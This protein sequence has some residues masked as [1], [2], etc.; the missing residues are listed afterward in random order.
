MLGPAEFVDR[1]LHGRAGQRVSASADQVAAGVDGSTL[2]PD[3]RYLAAP[4][5]SRGGFA[6]PRAMPAPAHIVASLKAAGLAPLFGDG[7]EQPTYPNGRDAGSLR[8]QRRRDLS[9]ERPAGAAGSSSSRTTI[10]AAWSA[11]RSRRAPTTTRA[12]WRCFWPS[13]TRWAARGPTL[14]RHVVLLFPDAEE[15]PDVRTERMGSSWFWRNSAAADRTARP[16]AGVRSGWAAARR[17]RFEP[18]ARGCAVR[19]RRRGGPEPGRARARRRARAR[20]RSPSGLA[21]R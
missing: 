20:G 18:R 17:P 21:C 9:R 5:S 16:G 19:P 3:V 14:R 8:G 13:R 7:F 11:A 4:A 6:A 1:V 15:P 10:T 2:E 12:R